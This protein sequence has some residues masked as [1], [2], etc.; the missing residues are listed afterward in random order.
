MLLIRAA[1]PTDD[2]SLVAFLDRLDAARRPSGFEAADLV[3]PREAFACASSPELGC[4]FV[5]VSEPDGLPEVVGAAAWCPLASGDAR[6]V[7]AVADGWRLGD[8]GDRLVAELAASADP[9]GVRRFVVDVVPHNA[10]LRASAR[11]LGMRERRR[12][13]GRTVLVEITIAAAAP[14]RG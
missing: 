9:R 3:P 6:A 13:D 1:A 4:A 7:L 5:A 14:G 10:A 8:V 12:T 11:R 2:T